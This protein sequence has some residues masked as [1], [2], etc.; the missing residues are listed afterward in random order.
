MAPLITRTLRDVPVKELRAL[1]REEAE[2]WSEELL[3]D[4]A[5]V[6]Q[7]VAAGVEARFVQSAN[8][9]EAFGV[10]ER[11]ATLPQLSSLSMPSPAPSQQTVGK[12]R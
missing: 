8:F 3:W 1:L 6:S 9:D 7:A 4:Y 5:E 11:H 2:Y 10:L 12:S